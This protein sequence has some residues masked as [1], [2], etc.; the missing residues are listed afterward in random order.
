MKAGFAPELRPFSPHVT[1]VRLRRSIRI[2]HAELGFLTADP[3]PNSFPVSKVALMESVL[4]PA[5]A[6]Y[7]CITAFPLK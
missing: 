2:P 6:I 4:D 7:R 1:L 5:G 3:W